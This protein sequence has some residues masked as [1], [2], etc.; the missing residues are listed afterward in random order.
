MPLSILDWDIVQIE[1]RLLETWLP[2]VLLR[3]EELA[4]SCG[5]RRG[6]LGAFIEDKNSGTI[7]LQQAR[8]RGLLARSIDSRLTAMGK[9]ERAIS[10]SGYVHRGLVKYTEHAFDKTVI[11]KRSSRNHLLDQVE[12][13]RIGDKQATGRTTFSTRSAMASPSRLEIV[14]GSNSSP[15]MTGSTL[16]P[17]RVTR[18]VIRLR[19]PDGAGTP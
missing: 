7:L 3:L 12:G 11:Y 13:F 10:V 2:S 19:H 4:R 1:G 9:V 18:L 6:S 15:R 5:A 8:R 17:A 14:K 16:R